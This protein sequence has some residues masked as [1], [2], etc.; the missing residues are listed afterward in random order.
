MERGGERKIIGRFAEMMR[1]CK[2]F[3]EYPLR[4]FVINEKRKSLFMYWLA[5][6]RENYA[7]SSAASIT[8]LAQ[9]VT[10]V[11]PYNNNNR[12]SKKKHV[13][14]AECWNLISF[15][16]WKFRLNI[17][18]YFRG[19]IYLFL[20]ALSSTFHFNIFPIWLKAHVERFWRLSKT[21]TIF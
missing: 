17:F 6:K 16:W 20:F 12:R 11:T 21:N 7:F 2:Q 14:S 9:N 15:S 18:A 19:V 4:K 5:K 8:P 3:R 10:K 1:W 13:T